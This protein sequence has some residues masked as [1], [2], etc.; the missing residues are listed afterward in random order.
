MIL[1]LVLFKALAGLSVDGV[2]NGVDEPLW[3]SF[4]EGLE[5]AAAEQRPL[6]VYVQAAWCG[7][8]RLLERTVFPELAPLMKRFILTRLDFDD[9]DAPVKSGSI[10]VSPFERSLLLGAQ[11]TPA[12]VLLAPDGTLIAR[13]TGYRSAD[14]LGLLLAYVA[15]GA[16]RHATLQA[17]LQQ[18]LAPS[19]EDR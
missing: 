17:Y 7:P 5:W 4:D 12:I 11:A 10:G 14:E 3:L 6:F 19:Y 15:T 1:V 8:C 16:Y 2:E 9:H 18:T 13:S